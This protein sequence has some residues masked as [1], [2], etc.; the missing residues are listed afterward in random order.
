MKEYAKVAKSLDPSL[1][2]PSEERGKG[3]EEEARPAINADRTASSGQLTTG[4]PGARTLSRPP[5]MNMITALDA[6]FEAAFSYVSNESKSGS[7]KV[8]SLSVSND[9]KLLLNGYGKVA[10]V[11]P[12]DASVKPRPS[13]LFAPLVEV[14]KWDSWNSLSKITKNQ[15]KIA[16]IKLVCKR[17]PLFTSSL[18]KSTVRLLDDPSKITSEEKAI[19]PV[20]ASFAATNNNNNNAT[21]SNSA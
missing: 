12:L 2:L 3:R 18:S 1:V 15:A 11:G 7:E 17:D 4:R 19:K 9:D 10:T 5:S 20:A 16:Y 21:T 14:R 13:G 8:T 6:D